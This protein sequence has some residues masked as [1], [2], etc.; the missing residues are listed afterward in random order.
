MKQRLF[1]L[2]GLCALSVSL[3]IP[4]GRVPAQPLHADI[5][6]PVLGQARLSST[7]VPD[8]PAGP[9]ARDVR[10]ANELG[11]VAS[12]ELYLVRDINPGIGSSR[13]GWWHELN[14]LL[15]FYADDGTIGPELWRSDGTEAGTVL[16][17]DINPGGGSLPEAIPDVATVG[18]LENRCSMRRQV[19][20]RC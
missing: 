7:P 6:T 15:L 10:A 4:L 11:S 19:G 16:V 14:G 17:K 13:A 5:G 3:L 8:L 2:L 20:F 1:Y 9:L 18:F 12:G